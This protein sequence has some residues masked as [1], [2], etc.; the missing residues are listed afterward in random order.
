F[1]KEAMGL[2]DVKLLAFLGAAL[3]YKA[4]TLTIF[5]GAVITLLFV[6]AFAAYLAL[7]FGLARLKARGTEVP[8]GPGLC[9]A[10]ALAIFFRVPA[11]ALFDSVALAF[12]VV[13]LGHP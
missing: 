7:R 9:V 8:F 1:R 2:G 12:R 5:A 6:L 13:I 4:A 11:E 3:G 10:A